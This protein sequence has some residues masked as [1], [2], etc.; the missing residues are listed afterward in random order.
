MNRLKKLRILWIPC[1]TTVALGCFGDAFAQTSYRVTDLGVLPNRNL[2]CA[3]GLNNRGWTEIM[4]GT[5]APGTENSASGKLLNGR[6]AIDIDGINFDLGT[7][8]GKNSWTQYGGIND[9]GEAVGIAETSVPD[10]NGEDICGFGTGL[11]CRP[12]LWQP[13][14]RMSALPTLGGNNGQASAINDHGKIAGYAENGLVDPTCPAGTSSNL[15][16]VVLPVLWDKGKAKALPTVSS[17][18]EGV[19]WGINNRGQATGYSGTCTSSHAVRWEDDT[20]IPLDDPGVKGF[21]QGIGIND[22]GEIIGFVSSG[23]TYYAA[24]WRGTAI[25]SLKTLPGDVNSFGESIN[26]QGQAVG[27]TQDSKGNWS[28]AFIW[29][30]GVMTDLNT[31][32]PESSNL[33]ATMAN[34]INDRGQISGMAVVRS[35]SREGEVHAFLATPTNERIDRSIADVAPNRPKSNVPANVGN[36]LLPRFRLGQLAR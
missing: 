19:A 5:L 21:S 15:N 13:G 16:R 9:R 32:F 2:G 3:M 7:L 24:I 10:P 31:L 20:V 12:F 25:T 14:G 6:A 33:Y 4:E 30:N 26:N 34:Q 1:V 36:Q 18:T 23:T 22:R 17:D 28:H 11:T 29:Q 8:G 27:S 35:G